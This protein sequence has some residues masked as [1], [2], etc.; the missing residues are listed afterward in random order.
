MEE[1]VSQLS[2]AIRHVK[3]SNRRA[4]GVTSTQRYLAPSWESRGSF[5]S[6]LRPKRNQGIVFV[7]TVTNT[8]LAF[9]GRAQAGRGG[10]VHVSSG[11]LHGSSVL[12]L[13]RNP[14]LF[15]FASSGALQ[16]PKTGR[17]SKMVRAKGSKWTF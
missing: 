11:S 3:V 16:V 12:R 10:L 4:T 1:T 9:V 7:E 14:A 6:A 13:E 2:L 5:S 8:L 15:C 17:V